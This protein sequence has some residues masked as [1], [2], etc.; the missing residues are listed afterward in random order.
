MEKLGFYILTLPFQNNM[1][2]ELSNEVIFEDVGKGRKGNHL[3]RV[4]NSEI[5]I[6]R[7]TTK[8][9]I[10]A[11][12][13]SPTHIHVLN[14]IES[15]VSVSNFSIPPLSINNALIEV[16]DETYTK[17]KYHSD[18][19]LDLEPN[20][21]IALFSCYEN[22]DEVTKQTLRKLKI[23]S[24]TSG[25]KFE[26]ILENNS[27][28][29]F[30]LEANEKFQHKI[31]LEQVSGKREENITNKWLGITFRQSKTKIHFKDSRPFFSNGKE[32]KLANELEAK[33]FYTLRGEENRSLSFIYPNI[34]YTLSI[35]DMLQPK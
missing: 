30:S 15:V 5:P 25:E 19:C 34:D 1:F 4:C 26:F 35:G 7:T 8:Y 31:V 24:K 27:V 12:N 2:E 10:P 14:S 23:K 9:D 6:V 3:V 13:F 11:H 21:Y 17:M 20:S 18:Q 16:Y 28:V 29:L 32:L 22:P 33:A